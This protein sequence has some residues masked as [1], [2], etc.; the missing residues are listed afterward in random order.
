MKQSI[1]TYESNREVHEDS[2]SEPGL[3]IDDTR[4][5]EAQSNSIWSFDPQGIISNF[6]GLSIF[7]CI[8]QL[9]YSEKKVVFMGNVDDQSLSPDRKHPLPPELVSR[10]FYLR[11]RI[12]RGLFKKQTSLN[13]HPRGMVSR[14]SDKDNTEAF[15]LLVID[16]SDFNLP[17]PTDVIVSPFSNKDWI[18][19]QEDTMNEND[20]AGAFK[21]SSIKLKRQINN[22]CNGTP[23]PANE[24]SEAYK[25]LDE[26]YYNDLLSVIEKKETS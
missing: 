4:L 11:N 12:K 19:D 23:I 1:I 7:E 18:K 17:I 9:I 21:F 16:P 2:L 10:K 25:I 3:D 14:S 6:Q 20:N 8:T 24:V 22:I 26:W 13:I 15:S 5:S